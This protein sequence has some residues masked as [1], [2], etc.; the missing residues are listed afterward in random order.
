M[1]NDYDELLLEGQDRKGMRWLASS[2][3]AGGTWD[4][5][6]SGPS[7][8]LVLSPPCQ[9][10]SLPMPPPYSHSQKPGTGEFHQEGKRRLR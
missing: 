4:L 2:R 10:L 9:A 8:H 5:P 3:G 6:E 7:P 1:S